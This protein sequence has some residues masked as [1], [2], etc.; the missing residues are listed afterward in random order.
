[1]G[2]QTAPSEPRILLSWPCARCG[3]SALD[4]ETTGRRC[5]RCVNRPGVEREELVSLTEFKRLLRR[6]AS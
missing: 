1:M 6:A 5:T 2:Q 3:G 4:E